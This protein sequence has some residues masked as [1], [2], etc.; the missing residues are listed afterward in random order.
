MAK[1]KRIKVKT[2]DHEVIDMS[3]PHVY[4]IRRVNM[5]LVLDQV[6]TSDLNT[7]RKVYGGWFPPCWEGSSPSLRVDGKELQWDSEAYLMQ[8]DSDRRVTITPY[9]G[10]KPP[11]EVKQNVAK[12]AYAMVKNYGSKRTI[13]IN[14]AAYGCLHG[15]VRVRAE[16]YPDKREIRLTASG[17]GLKLSNSGAGYEFSS[18]STINGLDI[19]SSVR[20]PVELCDGGIVFRYREGYHESA[21]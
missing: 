20:Y 1:R 14:R 7:A 21:G 3:E 13:Y 11:M 19:A 17:D 5:G 2:V 6:E 8:A 10:K 4:L 15:A 16:V 12:E 18:R 9:T